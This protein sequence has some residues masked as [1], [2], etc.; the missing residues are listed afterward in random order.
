MVQVK[1]STNHHYWWLSIKIISLPKYCVKTTIV[2][3]SMSLQYYYSLDQE[4]CDIWSPPYRPPHVVEGFTMVVL[5]IRTPG[6]SSLGVTSTLQQ[7]PGSVPGINQ[8]TTVGW[9]HLPP[10]SPARPPGVGKAVVCCYMHKSSTVALKLL[11]S[12]FWTT[13]PF[14]ALEVTTPVFLLLFQN[15][16]QESSFGSLWS[17]DRKN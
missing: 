16:G 4:C 13:E 2:D 10:V 3:P 15:G 11:I 12:D 7:R 9:L 6:H 1:W 17:Y 5:I 8:A 14:I